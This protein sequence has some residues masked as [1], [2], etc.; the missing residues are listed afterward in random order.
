MAAIVLQIEGLKA[1]EGNVAGASAELTSQV[2]W[3]MVQSTNTVKNTAQRLAPYKTGT[4]RRSIFTQI[5]D[6]G[7]KGTVA[8]DSS[9]ANYGSMVEYGTSAHAIDPLN[10]QALFW[11]GALHPYR[12]VMHPGTKAK[13]YMFPAL[14]GSLDDI[15]AYFSIALKNVVLKMAGR[16]V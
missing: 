8:Q 11:N 7:F 12:R 16:S 9:I 1:F 2:K 15:R 4:L 3:A 5:S 14:T 10:K 6:T 13:P